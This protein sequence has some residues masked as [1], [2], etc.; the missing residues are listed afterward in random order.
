[1][2]FSFHNFHTVVRINVGNKRT[3]LYTHI[4]KCA[5]AVT[6]EQLKSKEK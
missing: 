2:A 1:M 4:L 6:F 3:H 5:F